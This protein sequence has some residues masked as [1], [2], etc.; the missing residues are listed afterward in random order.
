M[1]GL[2]ARA[3]PVPPEHRAG[4]LRLAQGSRGSQIGVHQ[5]VTVGVE[6]A[7]FTSNQLSTFGTVL[8]TAVFESE[9]RKAPMPV[10]A[11]EDLR[12][13]EIIAWGMLHVNHS[14]GP[15]HSTR[16]ISST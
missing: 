12:S 13:S 3:V 1:R 16:C 7:D 2:S 15:V 9:K 6:L 10:G 4:L 14:S 11:S 8:P 5:P